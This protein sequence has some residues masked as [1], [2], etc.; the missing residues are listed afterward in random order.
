MKVTKKI[1]S[2]LLAVILCFATIVGFANNTAKTSVYASGNSAADKVGISM[3]SL[4]DPHMAEICGSVQNI[5]RYYGY[6]DYIAD[7]QNSADNQVDQINQF[8]DYQVDVIVVMPVNENALL[9]VLTKAASKNIAI[10]VIGENNGLYPKALYI[11]IDYAGLA[12]SN[13]DDFL[14][15]HYNAE[16]DSKVLIV[17]CNNQHGETYRTAIKNKFENTSVIRKEIIIDD[18]ERAANEIK[19]WIEENNWSLP[20]A[21][22]CCC[23]TSAKLVE[24]VLLELGFTFGP[25]GIPI[26]GLGSNSNI[27]DA[28]A[29]MLFEFVEKLL[30]GEIIPT[31]EVSEGTILV[32]PGEE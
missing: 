15:N 5:F 22:F 10:I 11:N 7:A 1:S 32:G 29:E 17:A 25:G 27:Y 13:A 18:V 12:E 16:S 3:P 21:I 28:L 19:K 6:T 23:Y 9:G 30:N 8:I 2:L 31:G 26:Y 4:Q 14:N 20:D 24:Q